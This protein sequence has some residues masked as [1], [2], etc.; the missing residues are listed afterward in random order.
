ML[1]IPHA[2]FHLDE[3]A[4]VVATLSCNARL[5]D[6]VYAVAVS[7][8]QQLLLPSD[9]LRTSLIDVDSYRVRTSNRKICCQI[10]NARVDG[11][12]VVAAAYS[13]ELPLYGFKAGLTNYA[14]AYSHELP[15]Y[16]VK[17]GLTTTR[18]PTAPACS[19][20]AAC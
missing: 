15:R 4:P 3:L 6:V 5:R 11:D 19:S 7:Y 18:P 16:V 20:R 14:A 17:A 1:Y 13:H 12:K 9:K 10:A 2:I 8:V